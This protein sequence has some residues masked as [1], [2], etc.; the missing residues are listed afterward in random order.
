MAQ[1]KHRWFNA[2]VK[3]P[4]GETIH[5][6]VFTN[7]QFQWI[8]ATGMHTGQLHPNATMIALATIEL[9]KMFKVSYD[10]VTVT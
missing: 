8:D 3:M 10:S 4:S 5:C 6:E 2:D 7:R 1:A 9:A